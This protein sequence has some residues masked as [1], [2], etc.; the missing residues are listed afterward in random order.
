M[1]RA[2]HGAT[3]A[4]AALD[5]AHAPP[6]PA[7]AGWLTPLFAAAV[8]GHAGRRARSCRAAPRA[9]SSC[10]RPAAAPSSARRARATRR[11]ADCSCSSAQAA[12]LLRRRRRAERRRGR[13]RAGMGRAR[14]RRGRRRCAA[15]ADGGAAARM[16]GRTP[17]P[18]RGA[19][20][21]AH[22]GGGGGAPAQPQAFDAA[23]NARA[24]GHESLAVWLDECVERDRNTRRSRRDGRCRGR[25]RDRERRG[26]AAAP[27]L[28]RVP[29]A[30]LRRALLRTG[31]T[32]A[33]RVAR[34][35]E[36]AR[37][38][39]GHRLAA[40]PKRPSTRTRT[41]R[42]RRVVWCRSSSCF[43]LSIRGARRHTPFL[44]DARAAR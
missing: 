2:A 8:R 43:R 29:R 25:R 7:P 11:S 26:A 38:A 40:R 41:A 14:R 18:R 21:D 32:I 9:R 28:R 39:R 3:M 33:P 6:P 17:M 44:R 1:A 36:H 4:S 35:L 20:A 37:P 15:G 19:A 10:R 22:D 16:S 42:G 30:A 5:G 13:A 23:E 12:V 24:H 34:V 31:V 27:P